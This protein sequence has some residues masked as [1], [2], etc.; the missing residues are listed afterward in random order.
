MASASGEPGACTTG[1]EPSA[2]GSL[3]RR[4]RFTKTPACWATVPS[5][6]ASQD[7]RK[8]FGYNTA[9]IVDFEPF[10]DRL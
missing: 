4:K 2:T 5:T 1:P 6:F 9:G 10:S 8:N 7:P 3:S